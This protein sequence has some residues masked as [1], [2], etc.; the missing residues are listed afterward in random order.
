MN[1]FKNSN[2]KTKYINLKN[3]VSYEIYGRLLCLNLNGYMCKTKAKK[4]P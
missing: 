4:Y 2:F 3:N 1:I